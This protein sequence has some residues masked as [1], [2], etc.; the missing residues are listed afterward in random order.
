VSLAPLSLLPQVVRSSCW[1]RP[2]S[3]RGSASNKKF[4]DETELL[5]L[6][7]AQSATHCAACAYDGGGGPA[8]RRRQLQGAL[9]DKPISG[10]IDYTIG[11]WNTDTWICENTLK[12][13]MALCTPW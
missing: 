8:V 1:P 10:S 6:M 3:G 7:L 2:N 5:A 9:D 4:Y 12:G 13:H 11:V